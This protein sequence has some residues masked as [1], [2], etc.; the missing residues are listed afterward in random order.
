MLARKGTL[1]PSSWLYQHKLLTV[2]AEAK[3]A[4]EPALE[5]APKPAPKLASRP[6]LKAVSKTVDPKSISATPAKARPAK[7]S[8][9][10]PRSPHH[11][12]LDSFLTYAKRVNLLS[13]TTA[14]VG[15]HY[16]YTVAASLQRLAFS[17]ARTGGKSNLGVDL[18]GH[19]NLSCF[20]KP[21]PVFVQCK[22]LKRKLDPKVVRELEGAFTGAPPGWRGQSVLALLAAPRE[23]TKGVREAIGRSRWPIGFL[24]ITVDGTVEEFLWNQSAA[25]RGLESVGVTLRYHSEGGTGRENVEKSVKSDVVLTWKGE[26]LS[27]SDTIAKTQPKNVRKRR[28]RLP[29]Q[30]IVPSALVTDVLK[31][32]T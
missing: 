23:A 21:L 2:K 32:D 14:Y 17:L 5:S 20:T 10:V 1:L 22:A 7:I 18:L 28:G 6:V 31:E 13:T 11:N 4:S 3:R 15:T 9:I 29:K 26:P 30:A 24:K 8:S 27:D 25:E 19:W 16:E 12:D